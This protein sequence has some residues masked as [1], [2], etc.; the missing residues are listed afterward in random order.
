M[1][2]SSNCPTRKHRVTHWVLLTIAVVGFGGASANNIQVSPAT[3]LDDDLNDGVAQVQFD[4]SWENSWRVT[5]APSNWDAAWVFMKFRVGASDPVLNG[6]SSAGTLITVPS[7]FA[8]RVGMRVIVTVGTGAF[9]AGSVITSIGSSTTF[10]VNYVPTTALAGATIQCNRIWEHAFL[11]NNGTHALPAAATGT[12]GLA[13]TSIAYSTSNPAVGIMIH[14][15]ADGTGTFSLEGCRLVW[16][17]GQQGID[18]G[19]TIE[20]C[21]HAIEMVWVPPGSF[22]LGRTGTN[23]FGYGTSRSSPYQVTS[24]NAIS[25]ASTFSPCCLSYGGAGDGSDF[26][27][28]FPKGFAGFYCMKYEISQAEFVAFLNKLTRLQQVMMV[29]TNTFVTPINFRYVMTNTITMIQRAAIRCPAMVDPFQPITFYCDAD[30]DGTG[31]EYNDGGCVAANFINGPTL[32]AYLDWCGLAP[33]SEMEFEKACRGP[34]A[35]AGDFA[36]GSSPMTLPGAQTNL[37]TPDETVTAVSNSSC[38]STSGIIGP[39]RVGQFAE[40][41]AS[42]ISAGGS[43]YGILDLSG[44]VMELTMSAGYLS[45]SFARQFHGDGTLLSTGMHNTVSWPTNGITGVAPRGGSWADAM[46]YQWVSDR[47]TMGLITPTRYNTIGGRGVR[48]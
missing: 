17:H 18:I 15:S 40:P 43:Y 31:D 45:N 38:C 23:A 21:V 25:Y 22:Y 9:T 6:A 42:R 4:L 14:R 11:G 30:G 27:T 44:N 8:L 29:A 3:L 1:E 28:Q 47:T 7:T 34:S 37:H 13:N 39:F 41:G 2:R 36:W 10:S 24:E 26:G 5:S 32:L 48:R 19:M 16:L 12:V 33:M 35:A 46:T 20:V